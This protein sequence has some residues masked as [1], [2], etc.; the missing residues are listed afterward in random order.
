MILDDFEL[1][2]KIKQ[3]DKD[4]FNLLFRRYYTSLCRFSFAICQS[5]EG[6]EENVQE[7]FFQ[8]WEKAP[9]L[10]IDISLK[11]YLYTSTRN[12]TLNSIK[13]KQIEQNYLEKYPDFIENNEDEGTIADTDLSN[14]IQAGVKTLP[15]KCREIFV[16]CKLEGLTYEEIANYLEVSTKTVDSQM[17]IALRKLR[18]YLYPKL[19]KMLIYLLF[20][21][22]F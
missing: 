1:F 11:A 19:Q 6:S 3:W 12:Y 2:A 5:R 14:L 15:E 17:G 4:A 16:M 13:K 21:F 20:S 7:M 22:L 10:E 18:E 8:L 9:H